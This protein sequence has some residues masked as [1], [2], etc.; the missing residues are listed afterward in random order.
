MFIGGA[1]PS[2]D[3][4]SSWKQVEE[5]KAFLFLPFWVWGGAR[6]SF[7]VRTNEPVNESTVRCGA[8]RQE[9]K[10]KKKGE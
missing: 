7:S 4:A 1:D 6:R 9:K 2:H 5:G 10:E 3:A 8:V